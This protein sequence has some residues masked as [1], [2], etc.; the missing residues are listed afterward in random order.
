MSTMEKYSTHQS[1]ESGDLIVKKYNA[2]AEEWASLLHTIYEKSIVG[3]IPALDFLYSHFQAEW[4]RQTVEFLLS[5]TD[6]WEITE[7]EV[8]SLEDNLQ[9]FGFICPSHEQIQEILHIDNMSYRSY[10]GKYIRMAVKAIW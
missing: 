9:Q 2:Q 6:T 8:A 1:K 5:N 10:D 4:T 7:E 3:G